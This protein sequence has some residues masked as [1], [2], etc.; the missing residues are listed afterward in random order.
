MN[1]SQK[2][3]SF[4]R[5]INKYAKEQSDAIRLEAEEFK[6]QEIEKATNEGLKDAYA[7]IQKEIS[8]QKAVIV[9]DVAK[10]EQESRKSLFIKRN[11]ITLSV[12]ADASEKLL[13]FTK[14]EKY[15]Q[16]IIDS[17]KD[18]AEIY[19]DNACVIYV[20][21]SDIDKAVLIKEHIKNCDVIC[22][23]S[24]KLG[25]VKGYCEA[26]SIIADCTLD[27]KLNDQRVWFAENSGLK[28]V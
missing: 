6:K 8:S 15:T 21:E 10:R 16:Y 4:L 11:E 2:T 13:E 7:L 12:F 28:V 24:I 3:S 25:G 5:A 1:E 14:T 17:L 27:T 9:S 22:D 26:L 20:K 18:I 19:K 23:N